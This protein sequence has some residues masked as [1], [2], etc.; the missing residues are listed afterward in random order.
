M[1][2]LFELLDPRATLVPDLTSQLALGTTGRIS[3]YEGGRGRKWHNIQCT[4]DTRTRNE[5]DK[6]GLDRGGAVTLIPREP[7]R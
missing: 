4:N 7:W 6:E 2:C 1:T 5:E 3:V